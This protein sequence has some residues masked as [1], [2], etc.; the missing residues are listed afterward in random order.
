[1]SDGMTE[2]MVIESDLLTMMLPHGCTNW[3]PSLAAC[4]DLRRLEST[5]EL[6]KVVNQFSMLLLHTYFTFYPL[7]IEACYRVAICRQIDC[8]R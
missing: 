3:L 7:L 6:V 8:D 4:N 2:W 5:R 1:M